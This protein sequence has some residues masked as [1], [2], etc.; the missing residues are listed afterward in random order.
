MSCFH[1]C[2]LRYLVKYLCESIHER[3]FI[4]NI[5]WITFIRFLLA[6][7]IE[8]QISYEW[9]DDS[10]H[11]VRFSG[12][13]QDAIIVINNLK[14]YGIAAAPYDK[15]IQCIERYPDTNQYVYS[16]ATVLN[17]DDRDLHQTYTFVQ[18]AE[19]LQTADVIFSLI[20]VNKSSC[21]V[22]WAHD[23]YIEE[24]LCDRQ[25][26]FRKN[27]R[28]RVVDDTLLRVTKHFTREDTRMNCT[29]VDNLLHDL[30]QE[31]KLNMVLSVSGVATQHKHASKNLATQLHRYAFDY[32][33]DVRGFQYAFVP[34]THPVMH[35][36]YV[37][38][39]NGKEMKI[40]DP[41]LWVW[42]KKDDGLSCPFKDHKGESVTNI[43]V[44]LNRE[45]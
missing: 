36:I 14:A 33:R 24:F 19:D 27:V 23:D 38:K 5:Q 25:A 42:K 12:N 35:N 3:H 20:R 2:S 32:A 30:G 17:L 22:Q 9:L 18:V 40:V 11:G 21:N 1:N 37:K 4:I 43:F 29:K 6:D 28:L 39:L 41:A 16:L 13:Y 10:A 34:T 26:C 31:L 45:K 7:S 15:P 44:D 8:C